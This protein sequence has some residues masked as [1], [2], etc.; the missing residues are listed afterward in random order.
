MKACIW[1]IAQVTSRALGLKWL[2]SVC[3]IIPKIIKLAQY[4]EVYS[5]R[6]TAF[7]AL[8]LTGSTSFGAN[9]LRKLGNTYYNS[10]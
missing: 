1:A 2:Q 8:G 4:C 10:L 7:F 9:L 3:E 5:V 6:A